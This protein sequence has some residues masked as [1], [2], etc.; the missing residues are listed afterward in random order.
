ML[1]GP[2]FGPILG[3]WLID[4]YS[5]HWI[6]LI[7]LP[8]GIA[9]IAYAWLALP[10]DRPE[11]SESFDVIGMLLMSPGLALFLYGISSIPGEGTF[12]SVKV[13]VPATIGV[14]MMLAFVL[15]SFR[16]K[17]PL[18]DLRLFVNRNFTVA[19]ITMFLF[20]ASFFGAL[21]LVPTYFQLVRGESPVDSGWLVAAQGRRCDGHHAHRRRARGPVP[22][23]PHRPRRA[24]AHHGRHVRTDPGHR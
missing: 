11:P 21:F 13:G 10:K 20:A 17:H 23:G 15:Y 5:W 2:I 12:F 18:L 22:R 16:P 9:A 7:N 4:H 24:A 1:L 8:L 19:T 14:L 3:G 6:F